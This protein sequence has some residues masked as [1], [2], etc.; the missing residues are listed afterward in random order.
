[1]TD[2]QRPTADLSYLR[3]DYGSSGH[4]L[5]EGDLAA[6]WWE[7]L[8]RWLAEAVVDAR[9]DQP[10]AA[11]LATASGEGEPSARTVLLKSFGPPGLVFATDRTSAKGRDLQANPRAALCLS[12]TVLERQVIA[13]GTVASTGQQESDAIFAARPRGAQLAAWTSEQSRVVGSR[14]ELDE[15]RA[16]VEQR[17]AGA[18]VPRPAHW[19]GYRLQPMAVEFWQGRPDRLHDRL[20]WRLAD[21]VWLLERLQP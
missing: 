18:A 7:Q 13:R 4:V 19:G 6:T 2:S 17:F 20:R 12:W 3:R 8:A 10:Q 11:V 1:V 21:G 15:R 5:D 9:Q 16:T 14:A